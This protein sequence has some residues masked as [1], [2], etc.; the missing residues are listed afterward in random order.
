MARL[1]RRVA[2]R[3]HLLHGF[4]FA[5]LLLILIPLLG[6]TTRSIGGAK[7]TLAV[8]FA[9]GLVAF[10]LHGLVDFNFH[11]PSNA[12]IAAVLSGML[13]GLPWKHAT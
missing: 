12:A 11:I 2:V 9:T 13:L 7:G 6:R 4:G 10:L 1:W 5:C 8:G 3:P